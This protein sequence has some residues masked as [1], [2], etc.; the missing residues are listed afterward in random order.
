ML[1]LNNS[2]IESLNFSIIKSFTN[3]IIFT[4][5]IKQEEKKT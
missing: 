4:R 5:E 1:Q 2:I 3:S